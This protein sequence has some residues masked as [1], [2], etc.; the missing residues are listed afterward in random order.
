MLELKENYFDHLTECFFLQNGGGLMDYYSWRK[1][2]TPQLVHFLKS[3]RLDSDDEDENPV[4]FL[5]EG[6]NIDEVNLN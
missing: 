5:K 2:P 1:R 6:K 4:I 3:G